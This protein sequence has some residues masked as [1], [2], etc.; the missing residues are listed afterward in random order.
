[1]ADEGASLDELLEEAQALLEEKK[2]RK[3][4]VGE[5]EFEFFQDSVSGH[6]IS[7]HKYRP[8]SRKPSELLKSATC[9]SFEGLIVF[10]YW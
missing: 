8:R 7:K 5:S 2:P 3:R 1:M 10:L 4:K 9:S 6:Q